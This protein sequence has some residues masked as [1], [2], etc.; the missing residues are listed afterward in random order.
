MSTPNTDDT[1]TGQL[2]KSRSDGPIYELSHLTLFL[3][4]LPGSFTHRLLKLIEKA[5]PQ[6]RELLRCVFPLEV[7]VW[8]TW[9]SCS[10]TPT[11]VQ[12][13]LIMTKQVTP[14]DAEDSV[15]SKIFYPA[16]DFTSTPVVDATVNDAKG[17]KMT[18]PYELMPIEIWEALDAR[19]QVPRGQGWVVH[20]ISDYGISLDTSATRRWLDAEHALRLLR[21]ELEDVREEFSKRNGKN[22]SIL[23]A[24][25]DELGACRTE[26]KA[27]RE[28]LSTRQK[29][30]STCREEL[31]T[32]QKELNARWEELNACRATL[33][34]YKRGR[35]RW[36]E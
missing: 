19:Y 2:R 23:W 11:P 20:G 17:V 28:E 34:L 1:N 27:R 18:E 26:L 3:D 36:M 10:F 7:R 4:R 13:K 14:A 29:E 21:Q 15:Y 16:V 33:A 24:K 35:T 6:N 5:S 9:M 32:C 31:S 22:A 30:L 25:V 8:E 12:L